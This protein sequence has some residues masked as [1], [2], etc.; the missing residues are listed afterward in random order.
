M[1]NVAAGVFVVCGL[2]VE[3]SACR[4]R[5]GLRHWNTAET[6]ILSG[7][8]CG[9]HKGAG[10]GR[11]LVTFAAPHPAT[12]GRGERSLPWHAFNTQK[13]VE[14]RDPVELNTYA[15]IAKKRACV[16]FRTRTDCLNANTSS[17]TI[18]PLRIGQNYTLLFS[19]KTW[20]ETHAL[21]FED[22]DYRL[23]LPIH[24]NGGLSS[25]RSP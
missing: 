23:L 9:W 25:R 15:T 10:I 1:G 6:A 3:A 4:W 18:G 5:V 8:G 11:T 19:T 21:T 20:T 24:P 14:W 22:L 2:P 16:T 17:D 7:G 12:P 13:A